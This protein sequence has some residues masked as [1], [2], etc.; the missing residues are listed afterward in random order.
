MLSTYNGTGLQRALA[1]AASKQ[2]PLRRVVWCMRSKIGTHKTTHKRRADD[3]GLR[4]DESSDS[5][6][7]VRSVEGGS[8]AT[9]WSVEAL[10][11]GKRDQ[12]VPRREYQ[13]RSGRRISRSRDL[14]IGNAALEY[15]LN[16]RDYRAQHLTFFLH[17][18]RLRVVVFKHQ[19]V[20]ARIFD[21]KRGEG[22]AQRDELAFDR[23]SR[24]LV[25]TFIQLGEK[26]ECKLT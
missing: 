7:R 18:H 25:E 26:S 22:F 13:R 24:D 16:A 20:S 15:G 6:G 10:G 11:T 4:G 12:A 3:S 21:R 19:A 8:I 1:R 23:V 14:T 17:Q 9:E 2:I 5:G